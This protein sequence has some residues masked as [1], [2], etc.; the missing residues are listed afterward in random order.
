VAALIYPCRAGSCL[1]GP[2]GKHRMDL[3]EHTMT[4][5]ISK[6]RRIPAFL[7]MQVMQEAQHLQAA[8]RDI[9]HLEVGQPSNPPPDAVNRALTAALSRTAT[10]GYSVAFG[11]P[12]LRQRI[13]AHYQ[14]W[15]GIVPDW[16]K[17][18]I[19]P[20]S[21][22]GF[23][24]SFL[25][26]FDA[27][28][29]IAIATPGYPAYRNLMTA[30]GLV[31]DLIPA[32][33]D[34]AW[35]PDLESLEQSGTLPDGILLASPANPT[36]VV[37][38][39]YDLAYICAWCAN[40]GVRLIMDEIYH[41]LTYGGRG[42]TALKFNQH[43]IIINSFSKYFCM[44][45]WRL[46]WVIL[47]DDLVDNAEKIAQ[48]LFISA[49]TPNQY[50]ALAAFDCYDE[51]DA[52]LPRYQN[53]RDC[54]LAGLPTEF[55]GQHAPAEGAFYLYVD[56]GAISDNAGDFARRMLHEAGVAV[57]PGVDFDQTEGE[58]YLRLSYAGSS[59]S[60]NIAIERINQWL[61]TIK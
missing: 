1:H 31:P 6:T 34:Q 12:A 35:M 44:T 46:G 29:H 25:A 16:N 38:R 20:G 60:I 53:N 32:R 26:A 48:N 36:G 8:G 21:S 19:T 51:F 50:G 18:A 17:I 47:P 28:D 10:H 5:K 41:G 61:P 42:T 45:G 39:D 49:P 56:I 57:T 7:A 59:S 30:L 23:A 3:A 37:I 55:L 13:S 2:S 11:Y 22:L 15:Y 27:G 4:L 33:A 40:H 58:R 9:I 52:H 43:A 54:L 14:D 24:I